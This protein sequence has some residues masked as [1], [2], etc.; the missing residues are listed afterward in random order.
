M[1]AYIDRIE[2][3]AEKYAELTEARID[4]ALKNHEDI[5]SKVMY[6]INDGIRMLNHIATTWLKMDQLNKD[7]NPTGQ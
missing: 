7:G 1:K 2:R 3:I 4:A 6:E 5:D